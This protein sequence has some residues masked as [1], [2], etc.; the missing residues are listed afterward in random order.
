MHIYKRKEY[1]NDNVF[2]PWKMRLEN[3][4]RVQ[5]RKI[6]QLAEFQKV[7]KIK[8]KIRKLKE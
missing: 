7:V 5:R 8:Y 3:I 6:I 4:V 1:V 2:Y